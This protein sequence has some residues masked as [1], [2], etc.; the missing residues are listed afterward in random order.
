MKLATRR[1]IDASA[2]LPAADRALLSLWT[3][4][5]LDDAA[6]AQM[7][8][9][10]VATIA[11][12]RVRIASA[13]SVELGLPP[14]DVDAALTAIAGSAAEAVAGSADAAQA[15]NGGAPRVDPI[16]PAAK[17]EAEV[18]PSTRQPEPRPEPEPEAAGRTR[19][20]SRGTHAS[21]AMDLAGCHA[22]GCRRH[23]DHRDHS[24][25]GGR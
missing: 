9:L 15:G 11:R 18:Q 7:T 6:M 25:L 12:R 4:R 14:D 3:Q 17:P 19:R 2:A 5:G 10:D 23:R 13:L 8:G 21:G 20:R 24:R 22:V 1:L 16:P